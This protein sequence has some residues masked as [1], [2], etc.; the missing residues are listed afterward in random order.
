MEHT[1]RLLYHLLENLKNNTKAGKSMN[2]EFLMRKMLEDKTPEK[3][4]MLENKTAE[5]RKRPQRR[6]NNA[7]TTSTEMAD[8]VS[9]EYSE[10]D[11]TKN[12]PVHHPSLYLF[13]DL[14]TLNLLL[15]QG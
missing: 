14:E 4:K 1:P 2:L 13:D 6:S 15:L 8:F 10:E 12:C 7:S 3:R 5:K 9:E 11:T